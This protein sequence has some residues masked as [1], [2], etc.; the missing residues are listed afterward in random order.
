MKLHQRGNTYHLR[1]RVPLDLVSVIGRK[2]IH[3][4][5]RTSHHRSARSKANQIK[6][7]MM[8][9]FETLRLA[10]NYRMPGRR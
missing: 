6:A 7:C 1:L 5:L 8:S 4:S 3:Q 2:E 9:G 10:Q